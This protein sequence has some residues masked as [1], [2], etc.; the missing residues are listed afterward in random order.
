ML[1]HP[2][3]H[4]SHAGIWLATA[5]GTRAVSRAEAIRVAADTPVILLNAPL[6][7]QR[8]GYAELSGLDL[9]ELFAFLHPARFAVPTPA[10]LARAV[11]LSPPDRDEDVASFLLEAAAA[12]LAVTETDW[13]EREGAWMAAASLQRLRWPWAPAVLERL[14]KPETNERWLFG[15]L[16][17]W[18]EGAPR[19]APRTVP[20]EPGEA[21]ARLATLTGAGAE[22]RPGQRAYAAAASA[23]F[24]P[25]A[26]RD[27]PNLVLAQ[28]GTGIGKTLG[29]LA[30]AA[31]W[32]EK[33]GG[34][35]WIS[36][37][38]KALQRQLAAETERLYPD[39]VLR[40]DRVVTR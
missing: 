25:R 22:A 1:P 18:E 29:Y 36:T 21:E 34:V 14:R 35:V 24:G 26:V 8:L 37:F 15:R 6:V 20:I 27:A 10:G 40:R 7:G 31:T 17:E 19:P 16:P 38:T 12:L 3:L 2:A 32:A 33:A 11:D 30:P 5:D 23:A 28:A 9:L 39:P 13:P 4:A